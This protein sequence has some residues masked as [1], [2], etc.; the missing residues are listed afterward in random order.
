MLKVVLQAEEKR[1]VRNFYVHKERKNFRERINGDKIK[2]YISYS[3]L[4]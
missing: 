1:Q 3:Y 2:S 4:I